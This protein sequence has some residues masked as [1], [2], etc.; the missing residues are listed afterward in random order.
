M[1]MRRFFVSLSKYPDVSDLIADHAVNRG[2]TGDGDIE[3]LISYRCQ[4]GIYSSKSSQTSC[5]RMLPSCNLKLGADGTVC[6]TK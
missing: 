1:R 6:F 4:L 3:D 2:C 5:G